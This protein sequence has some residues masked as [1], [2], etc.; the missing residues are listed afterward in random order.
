MSEISTS[1]TTDNLSNLNEEFSKLSISS[2][3]SKKPKVGFNF[4]ERMLLHKDTTNKHQECPERI[5]SIYLNLYLKNLVS[6][7]TKIPSI[8]STESQIL[9]VHSEAYLNSIKNLQFDLNGNIRDKNTSS[10]TLKEKDSYDNYATF[11][12]AKVASGS[13]INSVNYILEN[14]VDY[15][16]SIIRPPGHHAD[17]SNCKG[18]CIFN[19]VAIALGCSS[20]RWYSKNFLWK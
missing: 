10:H 2:Q 18:F 14:K 9:K 8:E 16:F 4:D 7:M 20:W 1:N 19:S 11:E 12:S 13:L 15:I 5:M 3:K 17:N 6:S